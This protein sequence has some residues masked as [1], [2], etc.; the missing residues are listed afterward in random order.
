MYSPTSALGI[1]PHYIFVNFIVGPTRSQTDLQGEAPPLHHHLS[2]GTQDSQAL[3]W[4][5]CGTQTLNLCSLDS[6]LGLL[7]KS[8]LIL[9]PLPHLWAPQGAASE[10][11]RHVWI[12]SVMDVLIPLS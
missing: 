3:T 12:Q 10:P 6:P 7:L 9:D 8:L 4:L 2:I 5:N 1:H 11:L